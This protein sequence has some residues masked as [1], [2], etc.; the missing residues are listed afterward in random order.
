MDDYEDALLACCARNWEAG[1]IVTRNTK[2]FANSPVRA[3]TPEDF[4]KIM[5]SE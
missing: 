2:D 3:L 4:L 5:S 1:C